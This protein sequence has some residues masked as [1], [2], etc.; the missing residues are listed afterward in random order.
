MDRRG[1]LKSLLAG[2]AVV[3]LPSLAAETVAEL[4]PVVGEEVA[5]AAGLTAWLRNSFSVFDAI[6]AAFMTVKTDDLPRLYGF[7]V[8]DISKD[9][10]VYD[11]ETDKPAA[12]CFNHKVIAVGME[13]DDPVEAERKLVAYV[14]DCLSEVAGENVP[15]F[16]RVAPTF[17]SERMTEYGDTYMTWEEINDRG[18][19]D[20]IPENVEMDFDTDTLKY[21]KRRYTLNKLRLRLSLPTQ[22]IDKEEALYIEEGTRPKRI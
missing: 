18:M 15:L 3:M 5:T 12:A 14:K 20:E 19:P 9:K 6:P 2:G 8:D 7:S 22:T 4:A 21:V 11:T 1:F 13:G 16:L 10:L 17:S